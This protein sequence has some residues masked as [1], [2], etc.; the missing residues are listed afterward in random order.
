GIFLGG[1]MAKL[2]G[3]VNSARLKKQINKGGL[4]LCVRVNNL[5]KEILARKIFKKYNAKS[6][7][8]HLAR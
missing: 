4:V 8:T 1:V 5:E 7:R 2:I 3:N 6:I